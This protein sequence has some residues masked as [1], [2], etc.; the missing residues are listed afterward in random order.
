MVWLMCNCGRY[1]RRCTVLM[2]HTCALIITALTCSIGLEHN[3]F[4]EDFFCI[5]SF[6]IQIFTQSDH[7]VKKSHPQVAFQF[8]VWG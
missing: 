3:F 6:A 4:S 7:E 2:K 5:S 1:S 8:P